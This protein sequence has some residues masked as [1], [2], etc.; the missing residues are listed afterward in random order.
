MIKFGKKLGAMIMSAVMAL[1]FAPAAALTSLAAE[2]VNSAPAAALEK[3]VPV[4]KQRRARIYY[5]SGRI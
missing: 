2:D 1:T 4:S 5:L 3:K